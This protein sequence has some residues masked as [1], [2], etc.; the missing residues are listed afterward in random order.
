MCNSGNDIFNQHLTA[1]IYET[2][3]KSISTKKE[4]YL[5]AKIPGNFSLPPLPMNK[6]SKCELNYTIIFHHW[7]AP[8]PSYENI[9]QIH[10][11]YY[12]KQILSMPHLLSSPSQI[13]HM[14]SQ[15]LACSLLCNI[16]TFLTDL[17]NLFPEAAQVSLP[18]S[19]HLLSNVNL[20]EQI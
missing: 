14:H 13:S 9:S 1:P 18:D 17:P 15:D 12:H 7:D 10:R 6:L 11:T 8:H 20:P 2:T 16:Q 5:N 3:I 4:I 19:P